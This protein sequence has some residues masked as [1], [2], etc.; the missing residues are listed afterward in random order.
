[1][2]MPTLRLVIDL[3]SCQTGA[4]HD[5]AFVLDQAKALARVGAAQGHMVLAAVN[6]AYPDSAAAVRAALTSE[7]GA[8]PARH[9]VSYAVPAPDSDWQRHA[10]EQLRAGWLAGFNADA[11][12]APGVFDIPQ[13]ATLYT[14]APHTLNVIGVGDAG[15]LAA[16]AGP[17]QALLCQQQQLLRQCDLVTLRDAALHIKL[18]A[19]LP[20]QSPAVP[21]DATEAGAAALFEAIRLAAQTLAA[22]Q[23][24]QAQPAGRPRLAYISPLPPEPSGIADY[25]AEVLEQIGQF[26]DIT[27]VATPGATPN[28]AMQRYPIIDAAAFAQQAAGF[29]RIVYHFGNS[30]MHKHMF[31]LL[32]AHPGVVVLH[33]FYL[34]GVLDNM[35]R[36][37]DVPGAFMQALHA[38]H[39]YG[40]LRHHTEH[41]RNPT[42]W[43]YPCN[44]EVLDHAA[45]VIVHS[46]YA[47]RLAEQWYGPGSADSW[48]TLPL[49]RGGAE[50]DPAARRAAARKALGIADDEFIVSSF[51]MLGAIKLNDRLLD[52]YLASPLAGQRQCHLV[53]VGANDAGPYGA[54]LQRR[55]QASD[56][57]D[58][59]RITGFAT[60][61]DYANWLAASDV[62]VQLR[63]MTRGE[64]SASILD[65]LLYGVPTIIN[66]HGA[67]ADLPDDVLV[68]LDDEF[69]T[70]D[71]AGALAS[72]Q[73]DAARRAHLS[74]VARAY[75]R[76]EHSPQ[77]VGLQY[78]DAIEHFHQRSGHAHYRRMVAALAQPGAPRPPSADA[79]T[80]L[81]RQIAANR[82]QLLPGH[83]QLLVD[84]SALVQTD[85]KTG[86][87]RVVRSVLLAL[88]ADPPAGYRVEPVYSAGVMHP[89]RYARRFMCA[90][91][92]GQ[93]PELEDAPIDTAAG[94]LFLGLDLAS[95]ITTQNEAQFKQMR[96][97]GVAIWF[98]VYDLLP[99]LRPD[100]FPYGTQKYYGDYINTVSR[101]ADGVAAI[102]R[103]VSDELA[104]WLASR[105]SQRA[106]PLQLGYFHLGADIAASAPSTG[107]PD[108][109]QQVLQAMQ[110]APTLLMVGTIEPRKGQAQALAALELLWQQGIAVNLVIVGKP[111]WLV[112][113]VVK[114][115]EQHP[116]RERRLF[117]L[118][119]VSD[120]ML[121]Q[122]YQGCAALLAASEGEGFGLP[123]IEAAQHGLP[124]IARDIPV[125][126][127][128][129]GEHA[130]YFDGK[131]PQALADAVRS[132][133]ALHAE[134]KAPASAGMPWLTWEQSARQLV[135]V[136]VH[137]RAHGSFAA[138]RVAPQLLV[139]VSA[140]AREDLKTG[141]Q[142]VVRAQLSELLR[143]PTTAF[144]VV[145]VY[146]T[147]EGNRWHY[148]Y[149][150]RYEHTMLG[151]DSYGVVDDEVR[152][153]AGDVF[154]SP[155]FFPGAV[156]EAAN[157]GLYA[158]WR[159]AGVSVNFLVHDILPVLRPD[160][161]PPNTDAVFERWLKAISGHAD[162]LVCISGA[163]ADETRQWLRQKLPHQAMPEMVVVHHGADID[164][165]QPSKGLPDDAPA[166][167]AD[168]AAAPSFL[169]V[170][171]I[172]PR[173]GHLQA[174]DA[175]EQLWAA[176]AD[177]RLV[178][179]GGEGWKGVPNAQ[180]RTI[181]A[182]ME[183][184]SSHPELG[185][186]LHWL[187]GISDEYL[188]RVYQSCACLLVPS[189]GEGFGLP[190]IE[191]ARHGVPL[192]ARDIPVFREVAREHAHY[193]SGNGGADLAGTIT[194]WLADS[195]AGKV[196]GSQGMPWQT[197]A[198][199]ARQLA[200]ALFGPETAAAMA[201]A[202]AARAGHADPAAPADRAGRAAGTANAAAASAINEP[203]ANAG[204]EL[205]TTP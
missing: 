47:K 198:D 161:F 11:V 6:E 21:A 120:E 75:I 73:G 182:I 109:A 146:L 31:A 29:E 154:Y 155:D 187:R 53:F 147:D 143:L 20:P 5:R 186:R 135:D 193:F 9:I 55:I 56:A 107:M 34:S 204:T 16:S 162:R 115:L 174:L 172:E 173:K 91:I 61:E 22:R 18:A 30:N 199:N 68:M 167:L 118:P 81:A 46:A 104:A 110:G 69:D 45:G 60:T 85:Y 90:M 183:R 150:R 72:L 133:L 165:S 156:T 96:L 74:D 138:G 87:Q 71:L 114:R 98:V 191:A 92:G 32:K 190:L 200:A 76:R 117:W 127:E 50:G 149:A 189:E 192:I 8:L 24:L 130:Y 58:R 203:L 27:L 15:Q 4:A 43:A 23:A 35:E 25:S 84:I 102:S 14:A 171:T 179:V 112:D 151:T 105:P 82:A 166:V 123:L 159:A 70:A 122:L 152:V 202:D 66:A 67:A 49:L 88:I 52:A 141:I 86:I 97:R 63:T 59:I 79:L 188:E 116:Q 78:R 64:S 33:D 95:N 145:P 121:L 2:N 158:R 40:G 170:G 38:S 139:D 93:A 137:G 94:D 164:A 108:N 51:G 144:Q 119:G 132:W 126:R 28:A 7:P 41:G 163:V 26:Y 184:L 44:K 201:T 12:Y 169:M 42:I 140:V 103:S 1:M 83:R 205:S 178:I 62:A 196:T 99:L 131:A 3:Q 36:D 80:P 13:T 175:F 148:R 113:Q 77:Q 194:A 142:R 157:T 181:P 57:R 160:F 89:Y 185:K 134:G 100:A 48:R 17:Q 197:W 106:Q 54:E 177:V 65:C 111:G 195:K 37:G 124:I 168:I 176:G 39:G 180:R 10:A 136:V 101:I 19:C 125:F 128:V 129:A 153:S